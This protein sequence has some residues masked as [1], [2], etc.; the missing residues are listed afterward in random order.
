MNIVGS[1]IA[2]NYFAQIS[3]GQ[4]NLTNIVK[5]AIPTSNMMNVAHKAVAASFLGTRIKPMM[6]P[7]FRM[8]QW[9]IRL[10]RNHGGDNL[11]G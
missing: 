4:A 5:P 11:G 9:R 7:E 8:S 3:F 2:E 10:I 6:F 1:Y